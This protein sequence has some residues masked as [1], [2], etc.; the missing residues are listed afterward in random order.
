MKLQ[1]FKLLV[2][3]TVVLHCGTVAIYAC[4]TVAPST[5][6]MVES[7][8]VIVRVEADR[9]ILEPKGDIRFLNEP[10]DAS[11]NFKVKE[12]LKGKGV[13]SEIVLNGY[14]SDEDDFNDTQI[15]Y[16]F[17]RR[18]GRGGSCSASEYK[19]GAQFLLFLKK[20]D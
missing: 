16:S 9:Y 5:T 6:G 8:D 17:V 18:D 1:K 4:R 14:L 2:L 15:P 3:F 20:I 12:T 11:I 13:P 7:S 19:K 10:S